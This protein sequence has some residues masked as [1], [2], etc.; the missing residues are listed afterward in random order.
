MQWIVDSNEYNAER[1]PPSEAPDLFGHWNLGALPVVGNVVEEPP[2]W[3]KVRSKPSHP[4]ES[5]C[6]CDHLSAI[7]Y[8]YVGTATVAVLLSGSVVDVS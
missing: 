5:A 4:S 6:A 1:Y 8:S 3:E 2:W 7:G